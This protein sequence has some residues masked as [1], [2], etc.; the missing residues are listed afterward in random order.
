M[1]RTQ[2]V[3][4]V[5]H[6][7]QS[8]PNSHTRAVGMS[9]PEWASEMIRKHNITNEELWNEEARIEDMRAEFERQQDI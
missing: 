2:L 6:S 9:D 5:Y 7:L 8:S 4:R 1:T 3:N